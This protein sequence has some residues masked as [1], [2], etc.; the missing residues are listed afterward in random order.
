MAVDAAQRDRVVRQRD[1]ERGADRERAVPQVLV[2][3]APED[4]LA[5]RATGRGGRHRGDRVGLARDAA[6]RHALERGAEPGEVAVGVDQPR[7]DRAAREVDDAR[8]GAGERAH[9]GVVTDRD[10]A[11]VADRHGARARPRR[12]HRDH[13][14]A[15]EDEVGRRRGGRGAVGA[16]AR[17]EP[18]QGDDG[19]DGDDDGRGDGEQA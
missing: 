17:G 15:D 18:G 1:V 3:A 19:D 14:A 11:A 5:R 10:D 16:A 4:P 6:Q 12:V 13:V 7:R 2:P 9:L 8:R